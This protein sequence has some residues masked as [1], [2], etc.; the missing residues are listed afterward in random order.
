MKTAVSIPDQ[1]F[2]SAEIFARRRGISRSELFAT[3]LRHYL[4][5]HQSEGI[6]QQLDSIYGAESSTL[7]PALVHMQA[8]SLASDE[9]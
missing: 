3:A 6:T 5:E 4:Q 9:W 1:L 7:E 8:R 2:E